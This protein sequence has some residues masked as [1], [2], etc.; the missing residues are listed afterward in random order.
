MTGSGLNPIVVINLIRCESLGLSTVNIN[1]AVSLIML[2]EGCRHC[3][4]TTGWRNRRKQ[5]FSD[6]RDFLLRNDKWL[7]SWFRFSRAVILLAIPMYFLLIIS[8]SANNR[9]YQQSQS[10]FLNF[11]PSSPLQSNPD[12]LDKWLSTLQSKISEP[13]GILQTYAH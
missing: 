9:L 7:I 4:R 13:I 12:T 2:H 5:G 3:W 6:H 11:T 10:P 1:T 8:I